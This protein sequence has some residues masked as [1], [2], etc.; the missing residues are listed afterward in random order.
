MDR[1]F[2]FDFPN[3]TSTCR[4]MDLHRMAFNLVGSFSKEVMPVLLRCG[5]SDDE[6]IR[7]Y[8]RCE[9]MEDI[10]K[11]ALNVNGENL[12]LFEKMAES[13]GEDFWKPMRESNCKVKSP[14]DEGFVFAPLPLCDTP[15]WQ[16]E[17]VLKSISVKDGKLSIDERVLKQESIVIPTDRHRE[18]YDMV[19]T[20]C[21]D[22]N[23]KKYKKRTI[24]DLFIYDKDGN[25]APNAAG[26]MFGTVGIY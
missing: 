17:K 22:F 18:L 15:A 9:S 14:K 4:F 20:F 7:K 11:D 5:V 19:A 21:E 16:K 6:H 26:I 1:K 3:L 24:R 23:S 2:K 10:Y 12:W 8:L 25:L 13:F